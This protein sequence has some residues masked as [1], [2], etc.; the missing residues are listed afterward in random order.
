MRSVSTRR[1]YRRIST[2]C[3]GFLFVHDSVQNVVVHDLSLNG[4]RIEGDSP[5]PRDRVVAVRV[6]LPDGTVLDIDRAV[7]RWSSET[8]CGLQII[9]LSNEADFR[10]ARHIE[11][12]LTGLSE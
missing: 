8:Q 6:W 9:A 11:C 4:L 7:V 3:R 10:L 1:M 2:E 5:P 12:R